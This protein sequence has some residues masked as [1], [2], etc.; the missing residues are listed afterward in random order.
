MKDCIV[1]KIMKAEIPAK[2]IYEDDV[3]I[4][5][6]DINP[7]V[8]GHVLIIPKEQFDNFYSIPDSILLHVYDVAR[9]LSKEI[10][11]KL[12]KTG[13]TLQINQGYTLVNHFHMHLLPDYETPKLEKTVDEIYEILK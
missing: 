11:S 5:I 2:K 6:L 13:I 7:V 4:A 10:V 1:C 3:V 8:E 9:K 12:N